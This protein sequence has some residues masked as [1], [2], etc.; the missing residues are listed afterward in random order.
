L[1]FIGIVKR[2]SAGVSIESFWATVK[3]RSLAPAGASSTRKREPASAPVVVPLGGEGDA[4]PV[5]LVD[6]GG[7]DQQLALEVLGLALVADLADGPAEGPG[8][9]GGAGARRDDR[10]EQGVGQGVVVERPVGHGDEAHRH[11]RRGL[12]RDLRT[13]L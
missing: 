6:L 10:G 13:C 8:E 9:G 1:V 3:R 2:T 12:A 11:H 5:E 4:D 7:A